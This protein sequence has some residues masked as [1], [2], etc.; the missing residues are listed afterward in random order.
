MNTD[1]YYSETIQSERVAEL[2]AHNFTSLRRV[3]HGIAVESG[4]WTDLETGEKIERN[5]GELFA[6]MHSEISEAMEAHRKNKMDDHLT[7]RQGVEVELADAVIRILD[8]CGAHNIDIGGALV[9]KLQYNVDRADHKLE[10]RKK[11]D[12]KKY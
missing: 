8:Y 11:A 12:G 6:L 2:I 5:H 7:H 3:C 9:E 1:N 10:S 4:W